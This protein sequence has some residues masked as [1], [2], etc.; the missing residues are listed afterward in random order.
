MSYRAV[1]WICVA[2]CCVAGVVGDYQL[3]EGVKTCKKDADDFS[4]CL[5]LAIQESWPVFVAGLPEFEMPQLDP[6]FVASHIANYDSG[7]LRGTLSATNTKTH[8]FADARFL[9]VKPEFENDV[10]HLIIDCEV[11]KILIE[12][13]YKAAGQLGSFPIGGTGIFNISVTD[14]KA[15]W[16][17]TGHVVNDRWVV[18]HFRLTPEVGQMKLWFSD[19]FNGNAEMNAAAM[20]FAN[21][22]WPLIYRGMLPTLRESW[23]GLLTDLVNHFFSK[24]PFSTLFP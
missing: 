24:L 22:Y 1:T 14:V 17:M 16:D 21:E 13:E 9:S 23:D 18:E 11:P 3:P 6:Y 19:L 4:S 10:F 7:Q 20:Y 15:N 2:L 12:G 8:G 5:R